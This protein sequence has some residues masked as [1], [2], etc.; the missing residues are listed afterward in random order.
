MPYHHKI[1]RKANIFDWKKGLYLFNWFGCKTFIHPSILLLTGY[2]ILPDLMVGKIMEAFTALQIFLMVFASI[3]LHEYGHV[4]MALKRK[5]KVGDIVLHCFGGIAFIDFDEKKGH[6]EIIIA[7]AGPAVSLALAIISGILWI[8]FLKF[9]PGF[10]LLF[11]FITHVLVIN[12]I[13]TVFNIIPIFPM[14][15]GRILRGGLNQW[16]GHYKAT[17]LTML[18]SLV[19]GTG[20]LIYGMLNGYYHMM[21][22]IG[23]VMLMGLTEFPGFKN[24]D[25]A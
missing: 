10:N 6:D 5:R 16:I 23:L 13:I 12:I 17:L 3:T 11:E 21:A 19:T 20:L 18:L 25:K 24:V 4:F 1:T 2:F 15:G 7:I 14:D 22:I 9:I 8:L